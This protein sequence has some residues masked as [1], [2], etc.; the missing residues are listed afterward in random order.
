MWILGPT[1]LVVAILSVAMPAI[2][3]VV[4]VGSAAAAAVVV[5]ILGF[6]GFAAPRRWCIHA[7]SIY[8]SSFCCSRRVPTK[9]KYSRGNDTREGRRVC[10]RGQEDAMRCSCGVS[11]PWSKNGDKIRGPRPQYTLSRLYFGGGYYLIF[12]LM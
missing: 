4:R 1:S 10:V 9:K 5:S 3:V 6:G 12:V 11:Y 8:S 7:V 2:A